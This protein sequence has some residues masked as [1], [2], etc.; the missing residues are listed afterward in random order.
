MCDFSKRSHVER[1]MASVLKEIGEKRLKAVFSFDSLSWSH[2]Q[3][4]REYCICDAIYLLFENNMALII[5]YLYVDELNMQY[6]SLSEEEKEKYGA[7][8]E[9]DWFNCSCDIYDF[10]TG[11]ICRIETC[12]LEYGSITGFSLQP[13]VGEY[14]KWVYV[15]DRATPVL[16][17]VTAT[18]ETFDGIELV[19]DNGGRIWIRPDEADSDGYVRLGSNTLRETIAEK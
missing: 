8:K 15:S 10:H 12:M 16:E 17:S 18:D 7:L 9:K 11:Q 5:D 2:R 19:M 4:V 6:R 1:Y 3:G 14:L 13:I